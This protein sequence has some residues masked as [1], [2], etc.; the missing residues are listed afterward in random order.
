MR[1]PNLKALIQSF[2]KAFNLAMTKF[3]YLDC[4]VSV[5]AFLPCQHILSVMPCY[6]LQALTYSKQWYPELENHRV[7]MRRVYGVDGIR[8]AG[9]NYA[10][11]FKS[12][13]ASL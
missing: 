4:S 9:E 13:S 10:F 12:N 11:R 1:H 7:N 5:L 8:T 6:F 2:K 3:L